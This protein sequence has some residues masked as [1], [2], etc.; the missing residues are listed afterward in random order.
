MPPYPI[1]G[2]EWDCGNGN[3]TLARVGI[4]LGEADL[5]MLGPHDL[6]RVTRRSR[7]LARQH[8]ETS[9]GR[10]ACG[11]G[12]WGC[13]LGHCSGGWLR[14]RSVGPVPSPR[15]PVW[16]RWATHK[17]ETSPCCFQDA[18][19]DPPPISTLAAIFESRSGKGR[20]PETLRIHPKATELIPERPYKAGGVRIIFFFFFS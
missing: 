12:Q 15:V 17:Q 2:R 14:P 5:A 3:T 20:S 11:Q 6:C 9:R 16:I 4:W 13:S 10:A 1:W 19:S 18:G 7:I 8:Q